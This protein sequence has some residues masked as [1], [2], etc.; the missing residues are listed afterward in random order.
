M[1]RDFATNKDR[2]GY[3]AEGEAEVEEVEDEIGPEEDEAEIEEDDE[4]DEEDDEGAPQKIS[5]AAMCV[6]VG[7]FHEPS[8]IGGLA[9]FCEHM[10]FMGSEKYPDENEFSSFV[11]K[12]GGSDNAHTDTNITVY[13]FDIRIG[14]KTGTFR[15]G[16]VRT[17]WTIISVQQNSKKL[18]TC[19]VNFLSS[20]L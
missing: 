5:A 7:G 16:P 11:S 3:D 2:H 10:L 1:T 19:G 4:G 6:E 14:S 20:L 17:F 9:H 15:I 12:F 13:S 8:S 18:W